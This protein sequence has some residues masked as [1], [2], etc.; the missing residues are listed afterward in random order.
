MSESSNGAPVVGVVMGSDSDWPVMKAAA[1]V[2]D[3]L[4]R[5]LLAQGDPDVA[6]AGGSGRAHDVLDPQFGED[7]RQGLGVV[8]GACP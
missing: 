4:G 7:P 3:E 5:H 8:V 2:L 6:A 1:E